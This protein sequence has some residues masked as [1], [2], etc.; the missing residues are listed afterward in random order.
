MKKIFILGAIIVASMSFAKTT[1]PKK[2][3][4]PKINSKELKVNAEIK[5]KA[6][7]DVQTYMID[8]P[9]KCGGISRVL[10][11]ADASAFAGQ[12]GITPFVAAYVDAYQF[13]YDNC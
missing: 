5:A 8:V 7:V 1:M 10:F 12:V 13:G 2:V 11:N 4:I 6:K 9:N 3:Y